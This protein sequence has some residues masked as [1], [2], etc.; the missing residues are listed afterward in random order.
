[1]RHSPSALTVFLSVLVVGVCQ[2]EP[3][4]ILKLEYGSSLRF[5]S[6]HAFLSIYNDSDAPLRICGDSVGCAELDFQ[7]ERKRDQWLPRLGKEPLI[8]NA[9]LEPGEQRDIAIDL[10][11]RYNLGGVGR[12]LV[13]AVIKH[14]NRFYMS[15]KVMLDVVEGIEVAKTVRGVRGYEDTTRNYSLR[16]W[17]RGKHE[18]LFLTVDDNP[19]RINQGVF[20]LGRLLRVDT[21]RI[22]VDRKGNVMILHRSSPDCFIRTK[23]KSDGEGVRFIDQTY[24]LPSGEPYPNL[25]PKSNLA[26][27]KR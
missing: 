10:S 7:I 18:Y 19:T 27:P 21:P 9:K 22:T 1:M 4:M 26:L 11:R 14:N 2:A 3:K 13:R 20:Q 16:Y 5:E 6:T 8:R 17:K 12:Y 24:E 25:R 15:D 23:F